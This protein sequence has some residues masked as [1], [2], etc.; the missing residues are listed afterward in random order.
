MEALEGLE[1]LSGCARRRAT[2]K[3]SAAKRA[4]LQRA[5]VRCYVEALFEVSNFECAIIERRGV[6]VEQ[7][8]PLSVVCGPVYFRLSGFGLA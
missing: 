1:R 6:R 7:T 2:E 8:A 4:S 3:T 5:I